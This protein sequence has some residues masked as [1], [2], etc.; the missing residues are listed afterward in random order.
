MTMEGRQ[1]SRCTRCEASLS[2]DDAPV[3]GQLS[4]PAEGMASHSTI[5]PL[6]QLCSWIETDWCCFS[7]GR[8]QSGTDALL[9]Q[10][11]KRVARVHGELAAIW[12]PQNGHSSKCI[13]QHPGEF[14]ASNEGLI[15]TLKVC[16]CM[17][18]IG[19]AFINAH[20]KKKRL[21]K[22]KNLHRDSG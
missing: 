7:I 14:K 8:Q 1:C 19:I 6:Y 12:V 22:L 5:I 17:V 11:F 2:W 20:S 10:P 21:E 13:A 9:G 3:S 18:A 15:D 16:N 4:K